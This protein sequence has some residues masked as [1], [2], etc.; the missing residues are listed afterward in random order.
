MCIPKFCL[1]IKGENIKEHQ[2]SCW[3]PNAQIITV[4]HEYEV[5]DLSTA[6]RPILNIYLFSE[7]FVSSQ[8]TLL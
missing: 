6:A 5:I 2:N 3:F 8:N 4:H 1:L 7:Y